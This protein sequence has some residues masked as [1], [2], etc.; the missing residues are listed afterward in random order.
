MSNLAPHSSF[1]GVHE[2][3]KAQIPETQ[4]V[5]HLHSADCILTSYCGEVLTGFCVL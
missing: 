5:A 2:C 3:L 4:V 1:C